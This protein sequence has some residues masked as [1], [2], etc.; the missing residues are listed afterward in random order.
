MGN[1]L[2]AIML[3]NDLLT[4]VSTATAQAQKISSLIQTARNENR[5]ITDAELDALRA[6]DDAA[7][8]ALEDL[9]KAK[10]ND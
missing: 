10:S 8:K 9:I 6:D 5:D 7:R 4:L 2:Q 1:A 3:L